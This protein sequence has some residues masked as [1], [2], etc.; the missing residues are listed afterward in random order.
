MYALSKFKINRL[1]LKTTTF[2]NQNRFVHEEN[3]NS[4]NHLRLDVRT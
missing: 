3:Q 2:A 4:G 1:N